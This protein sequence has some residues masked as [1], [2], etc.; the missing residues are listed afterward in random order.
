MR[1]VCSKLRG[2]FFS[3]TGLK[4]S[5]LTLIVLALSL[6]AGAAYAANYYIAPTGSGSDSNNGTST[7]TPWATFAHAIGA[8]NP[9]DTLNLMNGTYKTMVSHSGIGASSIMDIGNSGSSGNPITI[10]ALNKG[11]AVLNCGSTASGNDGIYNYGNYIT[12]K[13]L[14]ITN[15]GLGVFNANTTNEILFGNTIHDIVEGV[16]INDGS[17]DSIEDSNII[18]NFGENDNQ[19]HGLYGRGNGGTMQNNLI[20]GNNGQGYSIQIGSGSGTV[21]GVWKII[22]NT[23]VGTGNSSNACSTIYGGIAFTNLFMYNNICTGATKGLVSNLDNWGT[24]WYAEYNLID[25]ASVACYADGGSCSNATSANVKNNLYKTSAGFINASGGNYSLASGSAAIN[26]GTS[27]YAPAYDVI[28]AARPQD[29]GYSIGAYEYSGS[30]TQYTI[31]ASAGSGGGISPSGS[32][33]VSKGGNQSFTITPT[34]GYQIASVTVDGASVG[35]VAAYTFSSVSASHTI[36]A[37]FT[38]GATYTITATA[39]T[40]GSISPSGATTVTSGGT[41]TYTITPSSG[42]SISSVLVDGASVGAVSS[43]SFGGV[44]ANHTISAT[45]AAATTYTITAT[46]GANGSISP[47]GSVTVNKSAGQS[48]TITPKTGYLIASVT[49]DGASVGAVSAYSFSNVTANHTIAATFAVDPFTITASAGAG[50]SISPSGSVIVNYGASQSFTITPAA[51]YQISNVTVDGASVGAV[52][53]YTLN[54]VTANHTISATFAAGTTP[55]QTFSTNAGGGQYTSQSGVVY[56]ADTYYTGGTAASTTAAIT[57]TSDPTLY[58]SERYG[59]FSYNIPLANGNY[60]VT[61]KFAEIYWTA[62]G[63]RVF[64]VSMQ[65]TQVISNLDIYS[66]AGKN[67]AYDVTIPVSVTNG[68]LNIAFTSVVDYAK[69]SAIVVT[70]PSTSTGFAD[71]AGGGQYTSQSGVVYKA[72]TDYTGGTAAS[73]TAAITGSSDPALYQTE[74]YGN[75]SYNMPLANGNYTVTLKFAE[76]YWTAAGKRVFNVSMQ[77]TQVI[78]NLDIYSKVGKNAAYDVTIPVSVTNGMLNINF[79]TVVDNAKVSAIAV[80]PQ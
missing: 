54:S 68:T 2:S 59:N 63:K 15:C 65:G 61:L 12:I 42:Y 40:G 7:S 77:G 51:N 74:R 33:Q 58:Q 71:N 5:L 6:I 69:V 3:R 55:P 60:T 13:N 52:S 38:A 75:F 66:K 32:V 73:T 78:T 18:Y 20:Y 47:S 23:L 79:T 34:A 1:Y 57:G 39:G 4:F 48:F 11:Q 9:G 27:T 28:G 36:A 80:T 22:N 26:A 14:V 30:S 62:A 45:F 29:G 25:S 21:T 49:V 24:S 19:A 31:T 41:K 17:V 44:T 50:G 35:A 8:L 16:F 67:A 37:T 72:D 46:A 10:Q 43:Y 56:K 70:P 53:S 76:I 64:N